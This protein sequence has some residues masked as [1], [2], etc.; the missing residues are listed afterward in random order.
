MKWAG[1]GEVREFIDELSKHEAGGR[2]VG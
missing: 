1:L 2:R